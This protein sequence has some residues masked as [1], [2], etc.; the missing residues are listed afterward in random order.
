MGSPGTASCFSVVR[1]PAAAVAK[2]AAEAA[3]AARRRGDAAQAHRVREMAEY[4]AKVHAEH[5]RADAAAR[6]HALRHSAQQAALLRAK[7]AAAAAES[8]AKAHAIAAGA[9]AAR[10][11]AAAA[12]AATSSSG[13]PAIDVDVEIIVEAPP[14]AA[15]GDG[16]DLSA[17]DGDSSTGAVRAALGRGGALAKSPGTALTQPLAAPAA[18]A[19]AAA[20][21]NQEASAQQQRASMRHVVPRSERSSSAWNMNARQQQMKPR[22]MQLSPPLLLRVRALLL[23]QPA[24]AVASAP[25]RTESSSLKFLAGDLVGALRGYNAAWRAITLNTRQSVQELHK[26]PQQKRATFNLELRNRATAAILAFPS[27]CKAHAR[28]GAALAALRRHPEASASYAIAAECAPTPRDSVECRRQEDTQL[29]LAHDAEALQEIQVQLQQP[30]LR[31]PSGEDAAAA[32][33][34]AR[35]DIAAAAPALTSV[36]PVLSAVQAATQDAA[37]ALAGYM[38]M[39]DLARLERTCRL[40]GAC[41]LRRRVRI[42][43]AVRCQ[44]ALSLSRSAAAASPLSAPAAAAV[45]GMEAAVCAY[46]AAA[47]DADAREALAAVAAALAAVVQA[48]GTEAEK[49]AVVAAMMSVAVLQG[50]DIWVADV[51]TAKHLLREPTAAQEVRAR[52]IAAIAHI[53]LEQMEA[54]VHASKAGTLGGGAQTRAETFVQELALF[55]IFHGYGGALL[56]GSALGT[57]VTHYLETFAPLQAALPPRLLASRAPSALSAQQHAEIAAQLP[58][59]ATAGAARAHFAYSADAA[60]VRAALE[61]DPRTLRVWRAVLRPLG[62]WLAQNRWGYPAALAALALL[63]AARSDRREGV[64]VCGLTLSAYLLLC[65]EEWGSVALAQAAFERVTDSVEELAELFAGY[66]AMLRSYSYAL[67]QLDA[68]V[69]DLQHQQ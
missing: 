23:L 10:K 42:R 27:W 46:C 65:G 51:C 12:A 35:D 64:V 1:E 29:Q 66:Y 60:E 21:R 56:V 48:R 61:A 40:L 67:P 11:R 25:L 32:G 18:A 37:A 7:R 49:G 19:A 52:S 62:P 26:L 15:G 24:A 45:A 17:A 9:V 68:W 6:D 5:E 34:L 41:P 16:G 22:L 59:D 2:P 20:Q 4:A 50:P 30:L 53:A 63:N 55:L 3:A 44:R 43:R 58:H 47:T 39:S 54:V 38:D 31:R 8:E 33:V 28:R 13:R 69:A 14:A 57:A 36:G